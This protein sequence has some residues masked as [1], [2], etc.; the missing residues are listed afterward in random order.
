MKKNMKKVIAAALAGT[1]AAALLAGCNKPAAQ[2]TSETAAQEPVAE[3]P[4]VDQGEGEKMVGGY[5]AYPIIV[6]PVLTNE[7]KDA[8]D[9]AMESYDGT[10]M[11]AAALL[12]TQVVSGTNYIYAALGDTTWYIVKVYQ[13]LKGNAEVT[14]ATEINPAELKIKEGASD[15]NLLGGLKPAPKANA[16]VLPDD[17]NASFK[18]ATAEYVGVGLTPVALIATQLVS[19]TNYMMICQGTTVTAN[20]QEGVYFVTMYVDLQGEAKLIDVAAADLEAY[21]A[22]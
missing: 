10:K 6:T 2:T 13:D 1:M 21:T 22:Q 20:P 19:G 8:F 16:V 18:D 7:A 14:V 5:V 15:A 9:K 4:A 17:V 11:E 12:A 3:A